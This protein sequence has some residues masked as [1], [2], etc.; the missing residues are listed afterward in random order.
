MRDRWAHRGYETFPTYLTGNPCALKL[1]LS[2]GFS[3][4]RALHGGRP[5]MSPPSMSLFIVCARVLFAT[6]VSRGSGRCFPNAVDQGDQA[7][8]LTRAPAVA[9]PRCLD[10]AILSRR[11]NAFFLSLPD[12]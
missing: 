1:N 2:A 6:S 4:K 5:L 8:S 10:A 9:S 7:W 12:S 3:R 11:Q